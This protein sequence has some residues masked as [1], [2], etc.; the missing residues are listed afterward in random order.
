[1][2]K[3]LS[4]MFLAISAGSTFAAEQMPT[5]AKT[6][7]Q[8]VKK[9]IKKPASS[10]GKAIARAA[11][12]ATYERGLKQEAEGDIVSAMKSFHASAKAG[13][14]PAMKKLSQIYDKGN[15]VVPRNYE[16]AIK[17]FHKAKQA[18]V[19]FPTPIKR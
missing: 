13:F 11:A 8:E 19:I 18:G 9:E 6:D 5:T 14:G 16:T 4:V 10:D 2:N 7:T 17:W 3:I 1:M 15:S 12:P